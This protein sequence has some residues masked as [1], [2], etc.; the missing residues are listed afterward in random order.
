MVVDWLLQCSQSLS[1]IVQNRWET[2]SLPSYR[3]LPNA[4]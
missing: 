4:L 3:W 2:D 1:W